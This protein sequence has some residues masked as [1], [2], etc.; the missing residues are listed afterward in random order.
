MGLD[1]WLNKRTYVGGM[2]EHRKITGKV[3]IKRNGK[4][5][6][7]K[8][9]NINYVAEEVAYWRKCW[10]VH[11]FFGDYVA[12]GASDKAVEG[13]RCTIQQLKDLLALC[14]DVLNQTDESEVCYDFDDTISTD[15]LEETIRQ[16]E[17]IV[18]EHEKLKDTELYHD[19]DYVYQATW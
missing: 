18:E 13:I 16:I 10:A 2:Y 15:E 4:D 19:I 3:T 11:H 12:D 17:P 6:G 9:H 1:M 8:L 14:K 5:L 7:I